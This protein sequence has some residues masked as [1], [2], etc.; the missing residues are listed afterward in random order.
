[1]KST[2]GPAV[3]S[4][5]TSVGILTYHGV[6]NFGAV[7][8]A[9]ALCRA[10]AD[11]GHAPKIIDYRDPA[12]VAYKLFRAP[13]DRNSITYDILMLLGL[14]SHLK[15]RAR[16]EEFRSRHLPLTSRRF[17]REDELKQEPSAFDVYVSG[18]DQVWR[19]SA[20]NSAAGPVYFQDFVRTGRRVAY[21]PS[22][23]VSDLP[24]EY[25]EPVRRYLERF[26]FLSARE[27][28]GCAIIRTISGRDAEHVLDPT[29]LRPQA[30]YEA[31]A[32]E[33]PM[34]EPYILLYPM[35]WSDR[36][37]E[38]ALR[39]RAETKMPIVAVLPCFFAPWRFD[40]A[41]RV[42]FDAGPAEFLG[43]MKR[44]A[45]VCTNSF[46]GTCFSIIFRKTFLGVPHQG[47][48]TRSQSLLSRLGLLSRLVEEP[49]AIRWSDPTVS[50]LDYAEVEPRLRAAAKVSLDFLERAL[51]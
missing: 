44:A 9:F 28:T 11:L 3:P 7:L 31:V 22:F 29:L 30:D 4:K 5:A 19:T 6:Y 45:F 51:A 38:V 34:K 46:H 8:Q 50:K 48:A 18:S 35:Q 15:S 14:R 47:T 12:D 40:F 49:A 37:R 23:G 10:I 25:R 36:L 24:T 27:D 17:V 32:V 2:N 33:P 42:V 39:V 20:L 43:W 13:R 16:F 26:E 41:D 1:M 21:A